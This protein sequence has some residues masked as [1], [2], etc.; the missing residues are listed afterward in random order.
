[1]EGKGIM[2]VV[3]GGLKKGGRTHRIML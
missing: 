3:E 2:S 1:M